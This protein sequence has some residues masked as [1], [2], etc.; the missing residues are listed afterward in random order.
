MKKWIKTLI[1]TGAGALAGLIYYTLVG[2]P[3]GSCVI[4]SSVYSTMLYFGFMGLWISIIASGGCCCAGSCSV[5]G[6]EKE[7]P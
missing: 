6:K 7:N 1:F 4:T 3:S 5:D 2:C